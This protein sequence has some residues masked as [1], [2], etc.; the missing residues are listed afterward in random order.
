[1][2]P[3]A[4]V[5][6][7]TTAL[8]A[9]GVVWSQR[10]I[11]RQQQELRLLRDELQQLDVER[12]GL[13]ASRTP[14]EEERDQ[15]K[16][17]L[18]TLRDQNLRSEKDLSTLREKING[19]EARRAEWERDKQQ[20]EEAAKAAVLKAGADLSTKLLEDHKRENEEGKKQTQEITTRL[21][22]N[23]TG[24]VTRVEAMKEKTESV[25]GKMDLVMR[26]LTNPGGAGKMAEVGLENLLKELGFEPKRDFVMQYHIA[27]EDGA[28]ALRPDAVVFLPQNMVMVVDSKAS[29]FMLE[30]EEATGTEREQEVFA[31]FQKSMREHCKALA[32]KDYKSAIEDCYKRAGKSSKIDTVISLMYFPGEA[33]IERLK[34]HDHNVCEYLYKAGINM[35]G[36][37]TIRGYF[38]LAHSRLLEAQRQDKQEEIIQ[39]V[40]NLMESVINALS[41]MDKLGRGLQSAAETY[42]TMTGSLNKFVLPRMRRLAA[43]GVKPSKNKEIPAPLPVFDVH[44]SEMTLTLEA[45]EDEGEKV[46]AITAG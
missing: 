20:M 17:E 19:M 34:A 1:M 9:A 13:Q 42:K 21:M 27:G 23:V 35:V 26:A 12:A 38:A 46:I 22:E 40:A 5:L 3:I 8:T 10:H 43:H 31:Q 18:H 41:N 33:L 36:P 30:L 2:E 25:T 11:M 29:K 37:V 14:L 28:G 45:E 44:R 15:L 16:D 24:I 32:G 39:D 4:I 7:C 6:A